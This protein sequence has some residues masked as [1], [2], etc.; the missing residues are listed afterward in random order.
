MRVPGT[1][2]VDLQV[3]TPAWTGMNELFEMKI[4]NKTL[5]EDILLNGQPVLMVCD[6]HMQSYIQQQLV[7]IKEMQ[8]AL[9]GKLTIISRVG[10]SHEHGSTEEVLEIMHY[11][12]LTRTVHHNTYPT[13]IVR[14]AL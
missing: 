3:E 7:D 10:R 1:N 5:E 13:S 6:D 9:D 14:L 11:C 4:I 8:A 12:L 2:L